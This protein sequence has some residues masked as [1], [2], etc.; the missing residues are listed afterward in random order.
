MNRCLLFFWIALLPLRGFTQQVLLISNIDIV[1]VKT[2]KIHRGKFV[3]IEGNRITSIKGNAGISKDA[4]LIDGTG[5]YLVPGLWDMHA[6]TL[7]DKRYVYT[8]PLLIAN[9]VTGVREMGNNLPIAEVNQM[10]KD[11][12][13]GKILGPRFGAVTYNILDGA[14]TRLG[15]ATTVTTIEQARSIVRLYK[16]SGA[17]FIKPYNLLPADIYEAIVDEAT[18]QKILVEGHVPFSM[19]AAQV[20]GRKQKSIEHNFDIL[21][22]C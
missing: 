21:D 3:L 14:G 8:F 20:S 5:K 12:E 22:S 9:G 19:T 4:V 18:K 1:N 10:R 15:V 2:G 11:V 13:N 16:D 7:T 6:H 17:D